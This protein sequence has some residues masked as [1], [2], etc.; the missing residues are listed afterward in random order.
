MNLSSLDSPVQQWHDPL[1][2]EKRVRVFIKRDDM[3]H[4]FVSGNKWRK[5]KYPLAEALEKGYSRL[6]TF[7]GPWSNHLLAT[8]CAAAGSGLKSTGFVRG[9]QV[10]NLVL[11]LCS[12]FGM[13]L[14][15]TSREQYREKK[16]LFADRYGN[17]PSAYF[18]G[19]GGAGPLAAKGCAE[20]IAELPEEYDHIFCAA[21]TGTTAAGIQNGITA[22]KL[23]T[24]L[25]AVQVLKGDDFLSDQI[26]PTLTHN[27]DFQLHTSYHF[28]GYARTDKTLTR[29][30]RRFSST[31]GILLDPVYTGKLFYAVHHLTHTDFFAPGASILLIHTGGSTGIAGKLAELSDQ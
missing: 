16:V 10:T 13:E 23:H 8:A 6:V 29:F 25:H 18:I 3:L 27:A 2:N 11:T 12:I 9:E 20:L 1:F 19:E 4:P 7:G 31:T 26:R 17:D 28:G 22:T 21:G 15:F 5:L 24:I 14:I 30:I